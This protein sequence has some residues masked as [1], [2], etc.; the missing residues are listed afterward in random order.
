MA[1]VPVGIISA[2]ATAVGRP[3]LIMPIIAGIGQ[4]DSAEPSHVMWDLG[5]QR[6][7][8]HGGHGGIRIWSPRD[9]RPSSG[10]CCS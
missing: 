6:R 2:V 10:Q 3:D 9:T 4:V 7:S 5:R 8:Q 1:T